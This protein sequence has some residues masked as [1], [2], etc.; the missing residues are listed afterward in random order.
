MTASHALQ[1]AVRQLPPP[2]L[3]HPRTPRP[4]LRSRRASGWRAAST[5]PDRRRRRHH[6]PPALA[7]RG[8][9]PASRPRRARGPSPRRRSGPTGLVGLA[10]AGSSRRDHGPGHDDGDLAVPAA[11]E[12][13]VVEGVGQQV[14]DLAL[15]LRSEHVERR[16]RHDRRGHLRPDGEEAHLR[17]V[18][19]GD[20]DLRPAA[21][22][23]RD[24]APRRRHQVVALDLG[25]A[26]LAPPYQ[27]VAAEGDR[28][29]CHPR[30]SQRS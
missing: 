22:G 10:K 23:E 18:A 8:D 30:R 27:G 2:A 5:N 13:G 3:P 29:A 7:V 9:V 25:R 28:Q 16:R 1:A 20:D 6:P 4:A 14:A 15:R 24:Q 11:L 17:T 26:R 19:V 21:L 12:E